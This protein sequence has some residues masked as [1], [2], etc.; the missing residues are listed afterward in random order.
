MAIELEYNSIEQA[1][2]LA[3]GHDPIKPNE[4]HGR[5]RYG[6]F[7]F[8]TGL[9]VT[10]GE[11]IGLLVLPKGAR[12]VGGRVM[13]EAMGTSGALDL[14]LMGNDGSGYINT[15]GD[16]ADDDDK[17]LVAENISSAGQADFANTIALGCGYELEKECLLVATAETANWAA[18]KDLIGYVLYVV[19]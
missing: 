1:Q 18:D 2:H 10:D 7:T 11:N 9:G 13:W 4:L 17:F 12:I 19:D 14:G 3:V 5:V 16:S 6:R 15:A 8:N